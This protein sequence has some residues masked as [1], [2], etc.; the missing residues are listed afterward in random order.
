M[1][2]PA[3]PFLP[4]EDLRV[5]VQEGKFNGGVVATSYLHVNV[6]FSS[7]IAIF[8]NIAANGD[9]V[10]SRERNVKV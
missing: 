7:I 4:P 9:G 6:V 5:A 1:H 3:A 8:V 10:Q 2:M